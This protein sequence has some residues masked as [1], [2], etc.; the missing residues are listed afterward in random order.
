MIDEMNTEL[1]NARNPEEVALAIPRAAAMLREGKL[2]AF[3]TETV[4]GLGANAR[5]P[6]AV[7]RIFAAK[8][9]PTFD[10]L[11]VHVAERTDLADALSPEALSDPRVGALADAFWPGPLTIVAP[12]STSIPELVRAGLPTVGVRIPAHD[13]AR[14]LIRTAG[15]P[16][17]APSANLF[18][19]LSPTS[20]AHVVKQLDG[21]VDAIVVAEP[22]AIGVEST[23]VSLLPE[24]PARLLRPGGL[25]REMIENVLAPFGPLLGPAPQPTPSSALPAPGMTESHYAPR[26]RVRIIDVDAPDLRDLSRVALLAPDNE[27]LAR[28]DR[29][30]A[31]LTVVARTVLSERHDPVR[32]ASRLFELLHQ[33][34]QALQGDGGFNDT[35]LTTPYPEAGLGAAISD[36]LKRASAERRTE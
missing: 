18:G 5:D 31:G 19:Q 13:V 15:V 29:L 21:R 7:A 3:P 9:R 30:A 26:A 4:Y 22:S 34:D 1:L 6:L 28:L 33:L 10:P 2:V 20:A 17:A 14:A 12:A 11:I 23:I 25:P 16:I 32:A 35:I 27:T 24:E 8:E 36:R